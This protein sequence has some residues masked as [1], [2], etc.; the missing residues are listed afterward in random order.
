MSLLAALSAGRARQPCGG[1]TPPRA[2]GRAAARAGRRRG[3]SA[4]AGGG[5]EREG[6]RG[7]AE[8]APFVACDITGRKGRPGLSA[9]PGSVAVHLPG[10]QCPRCGCRLAPL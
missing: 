8:L 2:G 6:R 3:V 4:P 7:Q 9:R 1:L 5:E 10:G